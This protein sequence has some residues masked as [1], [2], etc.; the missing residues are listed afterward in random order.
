VTFS[1]EVVFGT[2]IAKLDVREI[3]SVLVNVVEKMAD[4]LIV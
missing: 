1:T 2:K 3:E 4:E